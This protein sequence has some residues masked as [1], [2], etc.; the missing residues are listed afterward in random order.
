MIDTSLRAPP[1]EPHVLD[2]G[3][4]GS[5]RVRTCDKDLDAV[6]LKLHLTTNAYGWG[7]RDDVAK[8]YRFQHEADAEA[9]RMSWIDVKYQARPK[10][11]R[12]Q[13]VGV[14]SFFDANER[15]LIRT[16]L[17]QTVP[18]VNKENDSATDGGFR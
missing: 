11:P 9:V 14:W 10:R 4:R 6:T 18:E 2:K 13:L 5:L 16:R 15:D 12:F 8:C 7:P 3:L 1:G 17:Q